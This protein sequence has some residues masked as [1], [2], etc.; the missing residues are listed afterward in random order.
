M[1]FS[2]R[3]VGLPLAERSVPTEQMLAEEGRAAFEA[4]MAKPDKVLY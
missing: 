2:T 3:E 4:W 1:N